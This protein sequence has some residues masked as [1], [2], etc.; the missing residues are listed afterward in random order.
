MKKDKKLLA[1]QATDY[2]LNKSTIA[3]Q[4]KALY[5]EADAS[6]LQLT[7]VKQR[8]DSVFFQLGVTTKENPE[9]CALKEYFSAIKKASYYFYEFIEKMITDA[10][11]GSN[12][13]EN[14]SL[15]YDN[16]SADANAFSRFTLL[17]IDRT[18]RDSDQHN[19]IFKILEDMES[20]G[21]FDEKDFE[22]FNMKYP[23]EE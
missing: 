3:N 23:G 16:W 14:R 8:I 11:W 12:D 4:L 5:L 15:S 1:E 2:I 18:F 21:Q 17:F 19:A 7:R 9:L 20:H 10:T 22:F 6:M 13:G